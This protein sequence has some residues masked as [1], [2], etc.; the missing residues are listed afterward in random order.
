MDDWAEGSGWGPD[1]NAGRLDA[2]MGGLPAIRAYADGDTV[3]EV[4]AD[5]RADLDY[6]ATEDARADIAEQLAVIAAQPEVRFYGADEGVVYDI[7]AVV[8]AATDG[9]QVLI[10]HVADGGCPLPGDRR[11]LA[12]LLDRVRNAVVNDVEDADARFDAFKA[13][14]VVAEMAGLLTAATAA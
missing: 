6:V 5:A 13:M 14:G 9:L 1:V 2:V 3:A 12:E 11:V 4:L 10:R 8:R 7:D